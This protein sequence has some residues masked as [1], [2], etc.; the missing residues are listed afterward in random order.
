M[1]AA[2][3]CILAATLTPAGTEFE[4]EFTGCLVCGAHGVSDVLVNLILFAPLGVALAL[5]GRTGARAVLLGGML[6]C[7]VEL[8]QIALPGRDPSLGDVTFNTLGTA[9]GQ[10]A[11]WLASRWQLPDSRTAAR[12]ALL[13]AVA[14]IAVFAATARMLEPWLP[15]RAFSAWYA[16]DL[17]N[18][19]WY[20]G[21]VLR[22]TLGPIAFGPDRMP[23]R[24]AVRHLLLEGAPL[25][26]DAIAA[27][28]VRGLAPLFVIVDDDDQEIFLVGPDRDD[29]VLRY[30]SRGA[31][32]RL[33]QPDLRLRQAFAPFAVGDTLHITV[34]RAGNG[35]CLSLNSA[36]R[37]GIGYTVGS[38]WALL[39]YPRHLPPWVVALLEAG[40]VAGLVF[41]VGLWARRNTATAI[42]IALPL[43]ALIVLPPLTGLV[44]TP[45]HQLAGAVLG[46]LSG[47][48]LHAWLRR[49]AA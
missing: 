31:R 37:C 6:S 49:R 35:Y 19:D 3:A 34:R 36:A 23:D 18:L 43:A 7:C 16:A 11:F 38:G 39:Y 22:T 45:L 10:V 28:R 44:R 42:A 21:R 14:A 24:D 33:D 27:R 9:A 4:P 5:N 13:A 48:A 26:I 2:V 15:A 29:L 41:P 25:R 32:W 20:H 12:L 8:A 17:P 30:R 47:G 46:L 1:A 40:W